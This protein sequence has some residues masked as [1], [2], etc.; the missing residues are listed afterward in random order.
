MEYHLWN[1]RQETANRLHFN[2]VADI[3]TKLNVKVTDYE[4]FVCYLSNFPLLFICVILNLDFKNSA[5]E[6]TRGARSKDIIVHLKVSHL[7]IIETFCTVLT[8]SIIF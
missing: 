4:Y 8:Y 5:K 2:L 6:S 7:P 3:K 1:W